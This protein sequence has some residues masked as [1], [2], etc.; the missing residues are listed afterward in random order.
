MPL[1]K[2]GPRTPSSLLQ[3]QRWGERGKATTSIDPLQRQRPSPATTDLAFPT[4]LESGDLV[5]VED[6]AS[7]EV[8]NVDLDSTDGEDEIVI[9]DDL[10]EDDDLEEH[11]EV[12]ALVPPVREGT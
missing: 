12:G 7:D 9:A 8:M 10:A 6:V 3:P 11:T 5:D 1:L 4:Q 2:N